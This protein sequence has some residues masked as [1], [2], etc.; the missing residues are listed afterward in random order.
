MSSQKML[1]RYKNVTCPICGALPKIHAL[2]T[3]SDKRPGIR[4]SDWNQYKVSCPKHHLDCGDWKDTKLN[5][6][7]D[8]LKRTKDTSQ[9]DFCFSDNHF[10]IQKMSVDEMAELLFRWSNDSLEVMK[11][12]RTVITA[13]SIK[14]WLKKP[15]DGLY[16]KGY[17]GVPKELQSKDL[18]IYGYRKRQAATK[19]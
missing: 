11:T 18:D 9:P 19:I 17:P 16:P 4:P 2:Y 6:Y 13:E 7:E 14:E 15:I 8:W 10:T 1:E 12:D 3:D 5:A